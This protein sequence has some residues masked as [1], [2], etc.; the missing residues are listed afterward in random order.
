MLS[1]FSKAADEEREWD[2][3]MYSTVRGLRLLTF[4]DLVKPRKKKK[5][6]KKKCQRKRKA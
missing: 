5:R 2:D 1:K 4:R 3:G 6:V